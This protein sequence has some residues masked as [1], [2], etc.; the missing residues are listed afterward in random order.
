MAFA[1]PKTGRLRNFCSV[2]ECE[3]E[4]CKQQQLEIDP[5]ADPEADE[6]AHQKAAMLA[7]FE[8]AMG[9]RAANKPAGER[10]MDEIMQG[11]LPG[12][13]ELIASD[14]E[15]IRYANMA[16]QTPLGT[17]AHWGKDEALALLLEAKCDANAKDTKGMAAIHHLVSDHIQPDHP[18][19]PAMMRCAMVLAEAK[20]NLSQRDEDSATVL[21]LV[22]EEEAFAMARRLL[23]AGA[24]PN[25]EFSGGGSLL[26]AVVANK[27]EDSVGLLLEFKADTQVAATKSG[28]TAL[29]IAA[30]GGATAIVKRLLEAKADVSVENAVGKTPLQLA[31]DSQRVECVQL[32]AGN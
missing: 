27:Q 17:A 6:L 21:E 4:E 9:G 5:N 1:L 25:T 3:A 16:G 7:E 2:P 31:T 11:H 29:H 14:P 18:F 10:L 32:L 15:C 23:E 13:E 20:A 12:V 8:A 28:M 26:N 22:L 19:L 30:R 24:D